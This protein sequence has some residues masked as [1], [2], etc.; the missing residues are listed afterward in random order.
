M[1]K[2]IIRSVSS[3]ISNGYI[4]CNDIEQ[5]D[6][7]A[8]TDSTLTFKENI[9]SLKESL[10]YAELPTDWKEVI[11]KQ[12]KCFRQHRRRYKTLIARTYKNGT[13]KYKYRCQICQGISYYRKKIKRGVKQ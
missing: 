6:L 8:L 10:H 13:V 7:K 12:K 3:W 11:N 4:L 1:D 9:Q 2:R 5:L